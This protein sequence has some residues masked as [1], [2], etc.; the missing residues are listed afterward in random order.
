MGV[1]YL[2]YGSITKVTKNIIHRDA[3][4][5]V[6]I[7]VNSF[8]TTQYRTVSFQREYINSIFNKIARVILDFA[9]CNIILYVTCYLHKT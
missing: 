2:F 6:L 9:K 5:V 4:C 8:N 7:Y 3:F 1:F